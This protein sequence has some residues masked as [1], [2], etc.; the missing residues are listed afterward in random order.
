MTCIVSIS[1]YEAFVPTQGFIIPLHIHISPPDKTF[2]SFHHSFFPS[3]HS[4]RLAL[5]FFWQHY[6]VKTLQLTKQT[7]MHILHA[8]IFPRA[9]LGSLV[10]LDWVFIWKWAVFV[11]IIKIIRLFI[12]VLILLRKARN[13]S[14]EVL[15]IL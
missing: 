1:D 2:L 10:Y 7:F 5:Y 14:Y 12:Q 4:D 15:D 13:N 3:I 8:S 9:E 11:I 6:L